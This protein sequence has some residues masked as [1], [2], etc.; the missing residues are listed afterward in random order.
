MGF[1][2]GNVSGQLT[3]T[4]ADK[5]QISK[6]SLCSPET[7]AY[8]TASSAL[9]LHGARLRHTWPFLYPLSHV[10]YVF[11]ERLIRDS[12]ES[13]DLSY[14]PMT[15]KPPSPLPAVPPFRNVHLVCRD[16]SC[17]PEVHKTKLCP[18]HLRHL[19][20]GPPEAVSR[21]RPQPRQNKLP[22]L[23]ETIS[24]TPGSQYEGRPE[25]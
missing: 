15:R 10:D 18:D 14:P 13:N 23:T 22:A 5:G 9:L 6:S 20:S 16:A 12:T 3:F 25:G 11:S 19:S 4:G 1:H 2:P 21:V 24:D 8:L 17:L 7:N